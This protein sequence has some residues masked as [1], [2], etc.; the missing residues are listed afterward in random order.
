MKTFSDPTFQQYLAQADIPDDYLIGGKF[1]NQWQHNYVPFTFS[2]HAINNEKKIMIF[3]LSEELFTSINNKMVYLGVNNDPTY[4]KAGVRQFIEPD[5]YLLQT[6]SAF[7]GNPLTPTARAGLP[8]R[9]IANKQQKYAE[10]MNF[11]NWLFQVDASFGVATRANNTI[12]SDLLVRYEGTANGNECVVLAGMEYKGVEYYAPIPQ[13]GGLFGSLFGGQQQTQG[14][15]QFGHGSPCDALEWGSDTRFIMICPKEFEKEASE[16]FLKFV[17][18]YTVNPA[19]I[20]Y[21]RQLVNE[22]C[23]QR[24]QFT[25]QAQGIARQNQMRTAQ[26]QRQTSQMIAQN[27]RDISAGIMDSWDKKMAS[28]DRM[29]QGFSQAI[30][31]VDTYQTMGDQNI[32]ASVSAD[33]VYENKYG[34]IFEVSGTMNDD[35]L[36][37]LNWTELQKK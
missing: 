14:S 29:S 22:R 32:E 3:A 26:L 35:L 37:K 9:N 15:T 5:A 4:I 33:H 1:N 16:T 12:Y 6:A 24:Q 30:R 20:S 31:G 23:Q 21:S 7:F 10:M 28:Q 13:M 25:A 18:T 11:Y 8:S 2:I 17:N 36:S 34:D 19:L 27:S